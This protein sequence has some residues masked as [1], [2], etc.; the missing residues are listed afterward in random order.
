MALPREQPRFAEDIGDIAITMFDPWPDDIDGQQSISYGII[1]HYN[2]GE[3]VERSNNL[4]PH[5]TSQ[6]IAALR[7]FMDSLRAQAREEILP[8]V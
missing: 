2:N 4:A 6:Q 5:L 3:R 8:T 7:N 1:V